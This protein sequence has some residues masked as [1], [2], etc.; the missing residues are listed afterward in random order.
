MT[1]ASAKGWFQPL[2][3]WPRTALRLL[4]SEP[5]VVRV[6]VAS[7]MGSAPR[8]AGT[9]MLLSRTQMFGTIGGGR[10][11]ELAIEY[12][13]AALDIDEPEV[14]TERLVL[15]TQ[16]AQ[17]CGGVV[18]LWIERY[19]R[20]DLP[21]LNEAARLA[22]AGGA[23]LMSV[24]TRGHITRRA[25]F[26]RASRSS[27]I[28]YARSDS[29]IT[30]WERLDEPLPSLWLYGAG[31]VGQAL[32]RMISDLPLHL[33]WIDSREGLLPAPLPETIEAVHAS[34]PETTVRNAPAGARYLVMTHSHTLDYA[35]CRTILERDDAGGV[36]VIGSS[37]KAARFRSRLRADGFTDAQI[38]QLTCPIGIENVTSKHPA[39]IA[40][41]VLAQLLQ[42]LESAQPKSAHSPLVSPCKNDCRNCGQVSVL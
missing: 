23:S 30:L 2:R 3:D 18:E 42:S 19:T 9:C 35:L 41:C 27:R 33:T 29:V 1:A 39:V 38:G 37:S 12:A 10:L 36:G 28:R 16:L 13:R 5:S 20:K 4:Q 6:V 14:R 22:A 32:A 40:V 31:H 21:L 26:D 8:E 11:E 7:V 25:A 17:C 34:N 15:G 24:L